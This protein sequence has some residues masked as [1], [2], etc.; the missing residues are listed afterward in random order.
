MIIKPN[1][2]LFMAGLFSALATPAIVRPESIM[3]VSSAWMNDEFEFSGFYA[4]YP[5]FGFL[6]AYLDG[7]SLTV[8]Q[9]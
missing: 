2:R 1:R 3:K 5:A 6:D 9:H 4:A 7:L 8:G